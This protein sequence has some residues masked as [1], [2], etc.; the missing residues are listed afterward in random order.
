MSRTARILC[1][2][3]STKGDS[4][5]NR[6]SI[7]LLVIMG[8]AAFLFGPSRAFAAVSLGSTVR[9]FAVLGGSTVTNTGS[10]VVTG[11][12]GVSPGPILQAAAGFP[13]GLIVGGTF[14]AN[15]ATAAL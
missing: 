10:S 11:N 12:V 3:T 9:T 4:D 13:P 8:F 6:K 5:M 2:A 14:H 15:D 7:R 1:G